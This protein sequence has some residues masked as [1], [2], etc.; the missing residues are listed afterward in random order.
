[1]TC[2]FTLVM[3]VLFIKRYFEFISQKNVRKSLNFYSSSLLKFLILSSAIFFILS[4]IY[5]IYY[6]KIILF[7]IIPFLIYNLFRY[8]NISIKKKLGE[9]PIDVVIKD[10]ILLIN[11]FLILFVI[12]I[13]YF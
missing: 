12:I 2:I 5:F 10:K 6:E 1:M 9:F 4:S 3:F 13:I 11:T 7:L 8:Y